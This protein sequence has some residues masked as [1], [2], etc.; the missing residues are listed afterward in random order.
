MYCLKCK[1]D[2]EDVDAKVVI[3]KNGK[4]MKK[5]RCGTCGKVKTRFIK[6][7]EGEGLLGKILFPKKGKIPVL[8]DIPVLGNILF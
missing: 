1:K 6:K 2:T 5:A 8:G 7:S 3:T 4:H